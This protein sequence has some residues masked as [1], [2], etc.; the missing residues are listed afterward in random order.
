MDRFGRLYSIVP[1]FT[2]MAIGLVLLGLADGATGVAVGVLIG[3]GNGLTSEP[4]SPGA[5]LAPEEEDYLAG[6]NLVTNL[7]L[8]RPSGGQPVAGSP[9][10]IDRCA[11]RS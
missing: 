7:R 3:G 8:R 1:A 2:V 9:A 10:T 6:F 11:R 4:C 5:D